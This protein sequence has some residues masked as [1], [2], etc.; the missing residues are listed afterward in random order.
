MIAFPDVNINKGVAEAVRFTSAYLAKSLE[1]RIKPF[2][3]VPVHDGG[4]DL[5]HGVVIK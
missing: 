2:V 1:R 3:E 4:E 5:V